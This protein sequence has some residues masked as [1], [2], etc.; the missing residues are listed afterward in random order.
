V[1]NDKWTWRQWEFAPKVDVEPMYWRQMEVW[2]KVASGE[3]AADYP[4]LADG[5]AVQEILDEVSNV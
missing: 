4:N 1:I 5:I 3:R 2:C